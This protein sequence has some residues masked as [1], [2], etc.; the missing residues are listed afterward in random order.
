MNSQQDTP[1]QK[2]SRELCE[3]GQIDCSKE[4][5]WAPRSN[6]YTTNTKEEYLSKQKNPNYTGYFVFFGFIF[7][8]V[9]II[10]LVVILIKISENK[11]A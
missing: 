4:V 8:L 10:L 5:D 7:A 11:T 2:N 9:I 1:L 6:S 3:T